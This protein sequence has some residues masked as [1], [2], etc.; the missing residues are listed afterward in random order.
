MS[1]RPRK[2]VAEGR[3]GRSRAN[4]RRSPAKVVDVLRG[5]IMEPGLKALWFS[6]T[7]DYK[8]I[9]PPIKFK[10]SSSFFSPD[11]FLTEPARLAILHSV[12]EFYGQM[13]KRN[14]LCLKKKGEKKGEALSRRTPS[15]L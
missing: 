12:S 4:F 13:T 8:I 10:V 9:S 7:V 3:G 14:R 15:P 5:E 6:V 2:I 1:R 11:T